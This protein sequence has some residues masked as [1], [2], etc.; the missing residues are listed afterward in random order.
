MQH[1]RVI[2]SA[3]I[4]IV[5]V[6]ASFVYAQTAP[7]RFEVSG[8][9]S[10]LKLSNPG[11]ITTGA[12]PRVTVNLSRWLSI[13]G[14]ITFYPNDDFVS[15]ASTPTLGLEY[16]RR[17]TDAFVGV[18]AGWRNER[19]GVFAKARPGAT[20]LEHKG[21]S[22]SGEVCALVLIAV[23]EYR[24]E[25][26]FDVGGVFEYYPTTRTLVRFDIS[27][28]VIDH[29]S[30]APPCTGCTSNNLTTRFAFGMRF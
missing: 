19:F 30:Y 2:L 21:V 23:P 24:T 25:F 29:R 7:S 1:T 13:D 5:L 4:T 10:V 27:D 20:W 9:V 14:D 15:D 11:S 17:R 26:A 22:C 8:Q 28:V 3:A 12:G 6:T 18:K 16:K